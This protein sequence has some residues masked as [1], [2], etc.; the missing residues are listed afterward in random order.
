MI[1]EEFIEKELVGLL[2][3]RDAE[4]LKTN[5]EKHGIEIMAITNNASCKSGCTPSKEVWAHP[6]DV[7]TIHTL[8]LRQ[9]LEALADLGADVRLLNEVFDPSQ[10]QATCPACGSKFETSLGSCSDCGLNFS[11]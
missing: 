11:L 3:A 4:I 9:R 5:M 1:Q 2:P 6:T 8:I 10:P 7:Q